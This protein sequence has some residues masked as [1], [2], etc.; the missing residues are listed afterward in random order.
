[1]RRAIVLAGGYGTRLAGLDGEAGELP[2]ALAPLGSVP[3]LEIVLRQLRDAGFDHVT[4]CLFWRA[5][6]IAE[7]FGDGSSLGLEL[8]YSVTEQRLGS[9][10]PL[11]AVDPAGEP[12]LVLNCD[13]LTTLDFGHVLD[14]H[15]EAGV[16]ATAVALRHESR[17]EY[18]MLELSEDG[19]R[20]EGHVEKPSVVHVISAGVN[21]LGPTAWRH[22]DPGAYLDMPALLHALLGEGAAI[23]ALLLGDDE[24][25][26]DMGRRDT[27]KEADQA[28][29]REPDRY[30]RGPAGRALLDRLA[31]APPSPTEERL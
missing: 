21:V 27:Y 15:L 22:L 11:A 17:L 6:M 24:S 30:L 23:T 8:V 9:A 28:F 18:G 5:E 4:L 12:H 25:W 1:M 10:G 16:T 2:K 29:R 19:N 3:I 31:A 7:Y 13:L 20:V 14:S 26:I